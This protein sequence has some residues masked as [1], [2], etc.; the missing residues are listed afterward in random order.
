MR[1]VVQRVLESS[2]KVDGE[3]IGQIGKGLLVLLAVE[4]N[5]GQEDLQY[6]Y[7]KVVNLRI[8][9]DQDG[10][11][12]R[13]LKDIGAE[14]LVVSQFT[15]Y[16]DVRKGRRPSFS[17]SAGPDFAKKYYEAFIDLAKN[18]SIYTETGE[19]G[20]DM[21]LSILNDG[22]VTILLDSNRVF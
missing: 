12:N 2:V 4:K 10:K 7:D 5:D 6:I 22:P 21:K 1:A 16:G 15:L 19:F 14:L 9:E 11:M 13:S 20:A 18:D 17:D 8:F 3:N